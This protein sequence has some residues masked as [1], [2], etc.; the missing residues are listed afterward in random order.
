MEREQGEGP[1]PE[2][3][4]EQGLGGEGPPPDMPEDPK[5]AGPAQEGLT[6]GPKGKKIQQR[7]LEENA[8]E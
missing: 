2:E 1:P 4:G 3:L 5:P 7:E 8:P 6:G